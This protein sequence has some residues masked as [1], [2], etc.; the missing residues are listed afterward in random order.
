L[1][2]ESG[3][4]FHCLAKGEKITMPNSNAGIFGGTPRLSAA[5]NGV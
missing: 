2:P 4:A 5:Q 3:R 1:I